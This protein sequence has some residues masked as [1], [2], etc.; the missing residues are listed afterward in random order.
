[1]RLQLPT[2]LGAFE[3]HQGYL[4]VTLITKGTACCGAHLRRYFYAQT[5]TNSASTCLRG[6]TRELHSSQS[7]ALLRQ[8]PATT[9][10]AASPLTTHLFRRVWRRFISHTVRLTERSSPLVTHPLNPRRISSSWES[11]R[12]ALESPWARRR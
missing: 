2:C 8:L 4:H 7:I 6:A 10:A 12:R 3:S 11:A 9:A 1:M 5:T